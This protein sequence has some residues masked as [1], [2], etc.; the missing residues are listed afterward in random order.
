MNAGLIRQGQSM[1][2]HSN[3]CSAQ[4]LQLEDA[5][6][7]SWP[8]ST[9]CVMSPAKWTTRRSRWR[10]WRPTTCAAPTRRPPRPCTKVRPVPLSSDAWGC[11]VVC[12]LRNRSMSS[13]VTSTRQRLF[14]RKRSLAATD[15]LGC[16]QCTSK[17]CP[18]WLQVLLKRGACRHARC[19]VLKA[20]LPASLGKISCHAH[21]DSVCALGQRSTRCACAATHAAARSRAL[22]GAA[23]RASARPCLTSWR[24]SWPRRSCRC[25]RPRRALSSLPWWPSARPN[26]L[27]CMA[28]RTHRARAPAQ[29]RRCRPSRPG[30]SAVC[31]W[32]VVGSAAVARDPSTTAPI[33]GSKSVQ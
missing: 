24:P 23:P 5:C 14:A 33:G 31:M 9:A 3:P 12:R 7:R 17:G 8:M 30:S 21:T 20:C 25:R 22:C 13:A 10:T 6:G 19:H 32:R 2:C 16:W 11:A 28:W 29:P 26:R 27:A 4:L 15:M 18:L 1:C